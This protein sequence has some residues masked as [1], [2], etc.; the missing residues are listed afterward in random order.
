MYD[1]AGETGTARR[2]W[3]RARTGIAVATANVDSGP[4][5]GTLS[6]LSEAYATYGIRLAKGRLGGEGLPR[7]VRWLHVS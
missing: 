2:R 4:V 3:V 1:A 6:F 7:L 5:Q